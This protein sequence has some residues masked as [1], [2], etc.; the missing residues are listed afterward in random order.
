MRKVAFA[1]AAAALTLLAGAVTAEAMT[2]S[3]TLDIRS[4]AKTFS[5]IGTVASGCQAP[6]A[7]WGGPGFADRSEGAGAPDAGA[8]PEGR[9]ARA[10]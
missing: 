8:R 9:H 4:T 10:V 2:G 6:F 5:P 7:G 1:I 3:G